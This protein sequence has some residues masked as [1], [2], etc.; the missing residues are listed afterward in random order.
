MAGQLVNSCIGD[1]SS[2]EVAHHFTYDSL[3][4]IVR[5]AAVSV[6]KSPTISGDQRLGFSER[7]EIQF[8]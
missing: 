7:V 3:T 5:Y 2:S 8:V 6:P 4:K 1:Y